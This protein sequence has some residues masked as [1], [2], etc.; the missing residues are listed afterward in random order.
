MFFVL[1]DINSISFTLLPGHESLQAMMGECWHG[2][3]T[4]NPLHDVDVCRLHPPLLARL[5]CQ[6]SMPHTLLAYT[7]TQLALTLTPT[8]TI[9]A[10]LSDFT[11]ICS[12]PFRWGWGS[13]I[14]S[15]PSACFFVLACLSFPL[16]LYLLLALA[17]GYARSRSFLSSLFMLSIALA[18]A[19]RENSSVEMSSHLL[20]SV[21]HCVPLQA[22]GFGWRRVHHK[23]VHLKKDGVNGTVNSWWTKQQSN[24]NSHRLTN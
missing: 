11:L 8:W 2:I 7:L 14:A 12:G 16:L 18:P 9:K 24:N 10:S 5:F 4:Q 1:W 22:A 20:C 19:A 21:V 23:R 3:Q 6:P 15:M 13:W 17:K